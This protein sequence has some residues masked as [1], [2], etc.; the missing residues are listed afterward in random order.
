MQ[1]LID[2]ATREILGVGTFPAA[3]PAGQEVV[4]LTPAQEG[5][6]TERGLKYHREDGTLD[7]VLPQQAIDDDNARERERVDRAAA[8]ATIKPLA[9]G[10]VGKPIAALTANEQRA[11]LAV[12]LWQAGAL[13]GAAA[14]R[15][16]GQWVRE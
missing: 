12:L 6:L 16:L 9:Q 4:E 15:P 13:D 1:A 10:A 5:R 11:L 14:I 8:V 3:P 2:S 7:V